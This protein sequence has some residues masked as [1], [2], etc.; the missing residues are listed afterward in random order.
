M[1]EKVVGSIY[2]VLEENEFLSE[3]DKSIFQKS[4]LEFFS[5]QYKKMWD[6]FQILVSTCISSGLFT[7]EEYKEILNM[8][9]YPHNVKK[10]NIKMCTK[11]EILAMIDSKENLYLKLDGRSIPKDDDNFYFDIQLLRFSYS[12]GSDL[13]ITTDKKNWKIC[14][15]IR[16]KIFWEMVVQDDSWRHYPKEEAKEIEFFDHVRMY[17]WGTLANMKPDKK[18]IEQSSW[19]DR[20]FYNDGNV[21]SYRVNM[22]P[23]RCYW[24]LYPQYSVRWTSEADAVDLTKLKILP[25]M[26]DKLQAIMNDKRAGWN[27]LTWPTG[28]WKSTT[29]Y[30][31]LNLIDRSKINCI[32]VEK[33]IESPMSW[34]C[35]TE[36]DAVP[37]AKWDR[38]TF[39][40]ALNAMLRQNPDLAFIWEMRDKEE[41]HGWVRF[42]IVWSKM[43]STIHTN[44]FA[45]TIVR[46]INE[47]VNRSVVATWITSIT[48]MRLIK[49]LCPKCSILDPDNEAHLRKIKLA[50]WRGKYVFNKSLK[51]FL[52]NADID[53]LETFYYEMPKKVRIIWETDFDEIIV[54]L[55]KNIENIRKIDTK[56]EK[57]DYILD[58]LKEYPNPKL[59]K[60]IDGIIKNASI[61]KA[62]KDWCIHCKHTW[63]V[64]KI[65]VIE[66]DILDRQ[67]QDFINDP[68]SNIMELEDYL[69]D[70]WFINMKMYWYLLVMLWRTSMD[71]LNEF[72]K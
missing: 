62:H 28:S 66:S 31:M 20:D 48:S 17:L 55:E 6:D 43:I 71:Y 26:I 25:F 68:N 41:I 45:H 9:L 53:V 34:V 61:R 52:Q 30:W 14:S 27:L 18:Q 37:W 63:Y 39:N 11:E 22:I 29:I 50:F 64:G 40:E 60:E 24:V 67:T 58:L 51:N 35:Q 72:V 5:V 70:K 59:S 1:I 16:F 32:S 3:S 13:Y 38:Y 56:E 19:F 8:Y 7:D 21:R 44:S 42:W 54:I 10:K 57:I 36:E 15:M 65:S 23:V 46:L 49:E 33:P 47:W 69:L 4:P 2:S 12:K